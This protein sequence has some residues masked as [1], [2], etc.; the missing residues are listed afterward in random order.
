MKCLAFVSICVLCIALVESGTDEDWPQV[1]HDTQHTFFSNSSI[2]GSLEIQWSYEVKSREEDRY[3][4]N[5]SSPAVVGE[6][7]YI[8][9]PASLICLDLSTGERLY[10]VPPYARCPSTPTVVDGRLYLAGN[11][12][13]FQCLNALTGDILWEKEL[14]DAHW[15]NPLSGDAVYVTEDNFYVQC[16]MGVDI[17]Y[18]W[19]APQWLTLLA[20]DKETGREIWRYSVEDDSVFDG[21]A[22]GFPILADETLFSYVCL[23]ETEENL[24][25]DQGKSYLVCI[26][27]HTGALKWKREGILP[28]SS[29]A[30]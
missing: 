2:S 16:P 18:C 10:E 24:S 1:G 14:N 23:Y 20:L 30:G 17:P 25:A 3:V 29:A 13:L 27:A 5:L 21:S 26:D 8:S 7:V 4:Y 15:I 22:L 28:S 6:R 11:E 9:S 19:R 12:N